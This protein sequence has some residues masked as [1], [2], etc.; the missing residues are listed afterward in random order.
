MKDNRQ[1]NGQ[2]KFT[3]K[4]LRMADEGRSIREISYITGVPQWKI[5]S[6]LQRDFANKMLAEEKEGK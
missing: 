1:D 4:V 3:T 6:I 2:S 5:A